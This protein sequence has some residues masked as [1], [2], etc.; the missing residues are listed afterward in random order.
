MACRPTS[1]VLPTTMPGLDAAAGHPHGEAVGVVV[2]AVAFLRH[3]RAAELAAPD[4][5][6][7]VEQAAALQ[8][9]EQAGDRLVHRAAES[10]RGCLS[11][12]AVGVPLAAGAAV[13]LDEPHAALDQAAGQQAVPADGLGRRIVQAV[14]GERLGGL[15]RQV[16]GLGGLGLH[17]EG[18][19]VALD[20][21]VELGLVGPRREMAAVEPV[22]Q[23][24]LALLPRRADLG[25]RRQVGDRLGAALEPRP[26]VDRRHEARAP[27]PRAAGDLRA[28]IVLHHDE[29]GQVLRSRSPG[30]R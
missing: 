30:R 1:S 9:L 17:A 12:S 25:G 2:A 5:Q 3:R 4:D 23:L 14:E 7:L 18:Q 21:G 15:A 19:L 11:M 13:E 26:L 20:P 29:A 28:R 10:W 16:D 24:E 8:V 6:G 22:Q 27:V